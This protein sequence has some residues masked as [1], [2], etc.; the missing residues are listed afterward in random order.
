[1]EYFI[2]LAF[3]ILVGMQSLI[4]VIIGLKIGLALNKGESISLPSPIKAYKE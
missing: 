3:L 2:I 4:C 1:M